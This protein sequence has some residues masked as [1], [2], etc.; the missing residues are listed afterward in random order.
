MRLPV[1]GGETASI[2]LDK[3]N[4]MVDTFIEAG[5]NYFDTSY[6]YHNG[7]SEIA[8][9][10]AVVERYPREDILIATKFP[11]GTDGTPLLKKA[12]GW[13]RSHHFSIEGS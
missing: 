12:E 5:Y 3:L 9:R 4:P 2:D 7:A 13:L 8:V 1:I 10:K 6:V 11:H